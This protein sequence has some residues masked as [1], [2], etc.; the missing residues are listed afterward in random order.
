MIDE[1]TDAPEVPDDAVNANAEDYVEEMVSD[2]EFEPVDEMEEVEEPVMVDDMPVAPQISYEAIE[3]RIEDQTP[4]EMTSEEA[5]EPVVSAEDELEEA[6]ID[7]GEHEPKAFSE[8][9][10]GQPGDAGNDEFSTATT[11]NDNSSSQTPP[12]PILDEAALIDIKLRIE[13]AR[14]LMQET[15]EDEPKRKFRPFAFLQR[16]TKKGRNQEET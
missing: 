4:E 16:F 15:N 13:N 9:E 3:G 11:S 10:D 6:E 14:L 8:P 5:L 7:D 2:V 1:P 12:E